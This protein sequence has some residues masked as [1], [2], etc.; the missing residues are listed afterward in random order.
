MTQ[1][2]KLIWK[3]VIPAQE[4]THAI[5][6]AKGVMPQIPVVMLVLI[7]ITAYAKASKS[8]FEHK[9][10]GLNYRQFEENKNKK[11]KYVGM[12]FTACTGS[13]NSTQDQASNGAITQDVKRVRNPY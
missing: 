9:N 13:R 6:A 4:L 11:M 7:R 3:L 12:L 8:G 2:I 1:E 10:P 5:V